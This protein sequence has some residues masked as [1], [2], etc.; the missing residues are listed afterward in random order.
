MHSDVRSLPACCTSATDKLESPNFYR[1][2]VSTRCQKPNSVALLDNN[3]LGLRPFLASQHR[4]WQLSYLDVWVQEIAPWGRIPVLDRTKSGIRLD[5]SRTE[6][7]LASRC[8]PCS[9]TYTSN[10]NASRS[11]ATNWPTVIVLYDLR[12]HISRLA[13]GISQPRVST[14]G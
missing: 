11:R 5:P 2:N 3:I 9:R 4:V 10:Q 14:C 6:D 7:S 13:V 12:G 8:S 1:V